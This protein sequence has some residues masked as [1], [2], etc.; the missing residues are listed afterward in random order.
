MRIGNEALA[1][2]GPASQSATASSIVTPQVSTPRRIAQSSA[3]GPRSPGGPG[4]TMRQRHRRQ[5]DAGIARFKNGARTTSG[6]NRYR[7]S[8]DSI[9]YIKLDR[10]LVA[11]AGQLDIEA[12][13]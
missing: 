11:V 6:V 4:C 9:L 12:L 2:T 7:V 13:R 5:T 10:E 1:Q 8:G 3:D